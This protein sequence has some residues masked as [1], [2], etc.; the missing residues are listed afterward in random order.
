[1][2]PDLLA[3]FKHLVDLENNPLIVSIPKQDP[4]TELAKEWFRATVVTME[5]RQFI[6][7]KLKTEIDKQDLFDSMNQ[8]FKP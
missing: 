8:K 3:R 4:Y 2:I 1:M 6:L 5:Q 7:N